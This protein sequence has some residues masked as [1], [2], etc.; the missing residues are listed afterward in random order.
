MIPCSEFQLHSEK[1]GNLSHGC[2]TFVETSHR[3]TRASRAVPTLIDARSQH[4]TGY[5]ATNKG[6]SLIITGTLA[7]AQVISMASNQ[8][9]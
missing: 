1:Y 5:Q 6:Y 7:S 3:P 9:Y 2:D 8:V 4:P